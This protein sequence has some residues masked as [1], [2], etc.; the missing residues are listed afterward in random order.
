MSEIEKQVITFKAIFKK[1]GK[2]LMVYKGEDG[3]C[4]L[5]GGRLDFGEGIVECFAREMVEELGWHG[6]KMGRIVNIWERD[7]RV[8]K[9]Q[10]VV[11]CVEAEPL[12]EPIVISDEHTGYGW[13]TLEE[14]QTKNI[15][16]EYI[17]TLKIL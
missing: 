1:D 11:V 15:W 13:F 5:P 4:E 16:P 6:V 7:G 14:I 12:D 3:F 2:F 17:Q 8:S 9:T 10:Y